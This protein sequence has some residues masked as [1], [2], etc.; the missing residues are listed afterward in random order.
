MPQM[1]P[2][3]ER[4]L[5]CIHFPAAVHAD[6]T[7]RIV[8]T[9]AGGSFAMTGLRLINGT[10]PCREISVASG[11]CCLT[12]YVIALEGEPEVWVLTSLS[13]DGQPK[14]QMNLDGDDVLL[15]FVRAVIEGGGRLVIEITPSGSH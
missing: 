2:S 5:L 7:D 11:T 8:E 4:A 14:C 9:E 3:I 12:R 13:E 6:S 15:D 1:F 10:K